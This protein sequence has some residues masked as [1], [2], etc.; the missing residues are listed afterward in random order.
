MPSNISQIAAKHGLGWGGNFNSMKDAMHFSAMRREGGNRDWNIFALNGSAFIKQAFDG[1]Y[2]DKTQMVLTHP[3]EYVVDADSVRLFGVQFYDII[4][5]TE[6]VFQR[7]R[8]SENLISILSQYTEDGF[9][10]TEDDYTY[11]A[12]E[13]SIAVSP[14]I[15]PVEDDFSVAGGSGFDPSK[16]SLYM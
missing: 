1:G 6:T 7:K 9:P 14:E 12:P 4:N 15:V 5:E 11:Y 2:I 10:E 3:G 13:S 8:A 16:D